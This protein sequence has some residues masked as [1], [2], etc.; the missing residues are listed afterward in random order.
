LVDKG[1]FD[2]LTNEIKR[3]DET[4]WTGSD[5]DDVCFVKGHDFVCLEKPA[6]ELGD[7]EGRIIS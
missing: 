6:I 3:G 2:A 7:N 4:D 5:D 1:D